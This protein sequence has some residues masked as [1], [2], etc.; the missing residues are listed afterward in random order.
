MPYERIKTIMKS[1]EFVLYHLE[2]ERLQEE[3]AA[4]GNDDEVECILDERKFKFMISREAPALIS[5]ACEIMI[6]ELSHRGWKHTVR[7]RRR[8]LQRPDIYAAVGE[9]ETFDFLI[10]IV[11]RTLPVSRPSYHAVAATSSAPHQAQ[12]FHVLDTRY[13]TAMVMQ[14]QAGTEAVEQQQDEDISHWADNI[15]NE[16]IE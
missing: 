16:S 11:P 9:S 8:T 2:K 4:A 3:N 15:Q 6:K 1:E 5:K 10:D 14:P 7:N 13:T 12:F